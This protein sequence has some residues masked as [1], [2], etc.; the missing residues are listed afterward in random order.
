MR[1]ESEV[2]AESMDSV[3]HADAHIWIE[4]FQDFTHGPSG[5]LQEEFQQR[6]VGV[7]ERPQEVIDGDVYVGHIKHVFVDIFDPAVH[8]DF[9][10][11]GVKAYLTGEGGAMLILATGV[12]PVCVAG[13][14]VT[15]EQHTLNNVL[16][17]RL[18]IEEDFVGQAEIAAALP[19][20][21]E[22]LTKAVVA[23]RV[24]GRPGREDLILKGR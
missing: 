15:A 6:A 10:V 18:L 19:V 20:G 5:D 21:E 17:V 9:P 23:A 2:A 16:N 3:G 22:Y 24:V 1:F 4:I 8:A 7:K 14:R 12:G 11:R 13:L